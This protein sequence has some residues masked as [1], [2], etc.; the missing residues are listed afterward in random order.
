[1]TVPFGAKKVAAAL[2]GDETK[3]RYCAGSVVLEQIGEIAPGVALY[4]WRQLNPARS[5]RCPSIRSKGPH[6]PDRKR[7]IRR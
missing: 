2:P 1:M 3:C 4:G 5:I 7:I 6:E